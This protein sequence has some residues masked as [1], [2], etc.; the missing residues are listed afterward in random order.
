SRSPPMSRFAAVD[1]RP[2]ATTCAL[3]CLSMRER[4][5]VKP[6]VLGPTGQYTSQRVR[7]GG[8]LGAGGGGGTKTPTVVPASVTYSSLRGPSASPRGSCSPLATTSTLTSA[9]V[10]GANGKSSAH[11]SPPGVLAAATRS[12]IHV[13]RFPDVFMT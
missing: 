10:A 11:A 4:R 2:S 3:P 12:A 7:V 6:G 5:P 9:A 1:G 13:R 8:S